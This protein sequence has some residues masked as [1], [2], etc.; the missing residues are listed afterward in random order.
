MEYKIIF[1]KKNQK[2]HIENDDYKSWWLFITPDLILLFCIAAV[3]MI[4]LGIYLAILIKRSRKHRNRSSSSFSSTD[5][6]KD[7]DPH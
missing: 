2:I 4:M 1:D 6:K 3:L 5:S 7:D